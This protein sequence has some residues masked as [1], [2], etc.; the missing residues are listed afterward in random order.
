MSATTVHPVVD[1]DRRRR[2]AAVAGDAAEVAKYIA[3]DCV[4][5][6]SSGAVETKDILVG[7]LASRDL[8]YHAM[9]PVESTLREYGTTV[10]I[11]GDLALEVTS[12][13]TQR[14]FTTRYL[15][16][17]L[18]RNG[19]WQLASWQSVGLPPK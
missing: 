8:V 13:G 11:N 19:S 3:D 6:H 1:L 5:V 4:Y 14:S 17:W 7:R 18:Q 9:V 16:V 12:A 2:E 10:L 15:A